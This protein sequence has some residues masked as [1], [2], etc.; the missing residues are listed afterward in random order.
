MNVETFN[1]YEVGRYDRVR[2]RG[3]VRAWRAMLRVLDGTA[4]L[5]DVKDTRLPQRKGA[6]ERSETGRWQ[7]PFILV[8]MIGAKG[9]VEIGVGR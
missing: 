6:A 8:V 9:A 2:N 7:G 5:S 1:G 3:T 4:G